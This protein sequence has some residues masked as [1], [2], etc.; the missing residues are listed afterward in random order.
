MTKYEE[1]TG[2]PATTIDFESLVQRA[3]T[4]ERFAVELKTHAFK[5]AKDGLGSEAWAGFVR[6]LTS[7]PTELLRLTNPNLE[8][9]GLR[10]GT[11]TI[12][13]VTTLT[14]VPCLFTTTTTTTGAI[15]A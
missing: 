14:T 3:C 11:T 5:A 2:K 9:E 10:A 13:T 4:D 7:N 12:T 15:A 1:H 6:Q 8:V